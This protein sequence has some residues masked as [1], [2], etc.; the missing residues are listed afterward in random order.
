M[1]PCTQMKGQSHMTAKE[2]QIQ[3]SDGEE[4]RAELLTKR[5]ARIEV[6]PV[7]DGPCRGS[8]VR[9]DRDPKIKKGMPKIEEVLHTPFECKSLVEFHCANQEV[10]LRTILMGQGADVRSGRG[11]DEE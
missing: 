7:G 4:G 5:I 8:I 3:F 6:T 9:L 10:L 1:F 11:D 2:I